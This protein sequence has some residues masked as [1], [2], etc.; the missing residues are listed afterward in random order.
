MLSKEGFAINAAHAATYDPAGRGWR[1]LHTVI[2]LTSSAAVIG[3]V[4]A[5]ESAKWGEKKGGELLLAAC[6]E[7]VVHFPLSFH[8]AV[9]GLKR[10]ASQPVS[11]ATGGMYWI[12]VSCLRDSAN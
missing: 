12:R 11:V 2:V 7:Q 8:E 5:E 9:Q 6:K 3:Q 10:L 1:V 4:S